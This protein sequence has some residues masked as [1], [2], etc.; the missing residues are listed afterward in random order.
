MVPLVS[1]GGNGCDEAAVGTG[2]VMGISAITV[3]E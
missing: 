3:I 1:I 2:N